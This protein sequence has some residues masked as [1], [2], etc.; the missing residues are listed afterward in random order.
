M[1]VYEAISSRRTIR[2]FEEKIVSKEI[3]EKIIGAGLMAPTND[4]LRNWEFVVVNDK[5]ARA[6]L[7]RVTTLKEKGEINHLLDLWEMCDEQQRD[8]YHKA[9]PKQYS[10]LYNAGC[11]I[12]PFFKVEEEFLK[13]DSLSSLNPFASMWCCIEN[14]LLAAASEGI[15]GV[16]RIPMTE[17]A[18]HIKRVVG[19]PDDYMLPC[20]VA[21]GYPSSK[22]VSAIQKKISVQD[23]MHINTWNK[24]AAC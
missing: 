12:L 4:H 2:D 6:E 8:M 21:L 1:D 24:K 14:M 3:I 15:F 5:S 18:E 13:P 19:H 23:R 16:T 9:L 7:L 20:Y 22:A 11:L 17:E 10:M